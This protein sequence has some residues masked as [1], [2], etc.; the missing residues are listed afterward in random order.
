MPRQQVYGKRSRAVYN[1]FAIFDSPQRPTVKSRAEEATQRLVEKVTGL[2]LHDCADVVEHRRRRLVLGAC[3]ANSVVLPVRPRKTKNGRRKKVVEVEVTIEHS[4]PQDVREVE[5]REDVEEIET[6]QA[7]RRVNDK[8]AEKEEAKEQ[9]DLVSSTEARRVSPEPPKRN[10]DNSIP[11][12]PTI[13]ALDLSFADLTDKPDDTTTI[14]AVPINNIYSNHSRTLLDLSSH[15]LTPFALWSSQLSDHFSLAKIA[16][17]SFGEVYRL[18]LLSPL[19]GLSRADESVFKVIALQAPKSILPIAKKA[20][21]AA[22]AKAEGMSKVEDVA[23]E[24]RV[25]QRMSSI[26]GF[27]NFR[28]VRIVQGRPPPLFVEAFQTYNAEQKAKKKDLSHFPDPV[29]KTSYCEDQ[30]W[31]VIEMQDA[32]TDLEQLV[33]AVE[34]ECT[35]IWS[36]WD[37]FWQV[38]LTLAKGEEG[39][40]FEH[41]DLHLGNI[42]VRHKNESTLSAST[43]NIDITS[44]KL[45]F[46]DLETT[47][48]DYTISR[49]RLTSKTHPF[50]DP[51]QEIAYHDL[52]PDPSLFQGDS[53]EEYQYDI[54][55]Y[56]RGAVLAQDPMSNEDMPDNKDIWQQYHPT[57]NLI[58]LHFILYK[59]LEQLSWPSSQKP[60]SRKL[61]VAVKPAFAEWKRAN[62]LEHTLLHMQDLLDPETG[63]CKSSL[64]SAS[65]IVALALSEGWL[66]VEDVVGCHNDV[67][68]GMMVG[69]E[70]DVVSSSPPGTVYLTTDECVAVPQSSDPPA[71]LT[72]EDAPTH[73]QINIDIMEEKGLEAATHAARKTRRKDRARR[74]RSTL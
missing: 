9:Q 23:S 31:A 69:G 65:D 35:S 6:R 1:D 66:G 40:E 72:F 53:T 29:K 26:P 36:V 2:S 3:D 68:T 7:E 74:R 47:I 49:C 14:A 15:D 32:G 61:K 63:I 13:S 44:K 48:I 18:S 58:W 33:E 41:R 19:P 27:T 64:R 20:R 70:G 46:T 16:E 4:G 56:M 42:C 43:A 39:A 22:L 57:T 10:R 30:L 5:S 28:D 21:A 37:V 55:R 73:I 50:S 45:G 62:D 17:A 24:V 34:G 8:T 51:E 12:A 52:L 11:Q 38:V 59:L 67:Y 25:L 71:L 60:P 54:Y